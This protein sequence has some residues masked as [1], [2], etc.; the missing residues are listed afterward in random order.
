MDA[1]KRKVI[2]SMM[3]VRQQLKKQAEEI[4]LCARKLCDHTKEDG[5]LDLSGG[6]SVL[7]SENVALVV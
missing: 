5:T 7:M 4:K 2:E 3:L 1:A 6:F